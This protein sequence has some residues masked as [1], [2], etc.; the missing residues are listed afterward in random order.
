MQFKDIT[1][2]TFG[3]LTV[4]ERI[5]NDKNKKVRW[6]CKCEC[7]RETV[8]CTG[9]LKS[10]NTK[11]CGCVRYWSGADNPSWKGGRIVK[12]G[13]IMILAPESAMAEQ[14]GYVFEHRLVMARMIGRDLEPQEVV[15]HKDGDQTNNNS[16]NLELFPSVVEHIARHRESKST[17]KERA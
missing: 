6:V 12:N 3:K 13:Y 16:S 1:R 11:S 10:G 5:A 2:Q 14:H 7:G 4:V 15:H 17:D 8:V 9:D